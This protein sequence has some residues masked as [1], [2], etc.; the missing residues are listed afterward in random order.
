MERVCV[1]RFTQSEAAEEVGQGSGG[2]GG[3][4]LEVGASKE[5]EATHVVPGE[6][7]LFT[8]LGDVLRGKYTGACSSCFEE[9][10]GPLQMTFDLRLLSLSAGAGAGGW[11]GEAAEVQTVFV[12]EAGLTE[13]EGL[14]VLEQGEGVRKEVGDGRRQVGLKGGQNLDGSCVVGGGVVLAADAAAVAGC[15]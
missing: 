7:M 8:E 13:E 6:G 2:I 14:F 1:K 9:G 15:R 12:R 5:E 10:E 11:G 4:G 3:V